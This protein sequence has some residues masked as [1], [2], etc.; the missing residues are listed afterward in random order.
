MKDASMIIG[1][2][3]TA[4]KARDFTGILSIQVQTIIFSYLDLS[5]LLRCT[6][7]SRRWQRIILDNNACFSSLSIKSANAIYRTK[8]PQKV[9][10][11]ICKAAKG[12]VRNMVI[13]TSVVPTSQ[14]ALIK[15]SC[16][17]KLNSLR[18]FTSG[19]PLRLDASEYYLP[20]SR[21]QYAKL[22][23]L[24]LS[25]S[26]C[27]DDLVKLLHNIPSL[28]Q[29]K[30]SD[31]IGFPYN[32]STFKNVLK[33]YHSE[34]SNVRYLDATVSIAA[35]MPEL[36]C[37]EP[38]LASL[39]PNLEEIVLNDYMLKC[40]GCLVNF[41]NVKRLTLRQCDTDVGI[42]ELP[43]S[44]K[45]FKVIACQKIGKEDT[46]KLSK[47]EIDT[48][49]LIDCYSIKSRDIDDFLDY[50]HISLTHLH[51]INSILPDA[52]TILYVSMEFPNLQYVKL[53]QLPYITD[54]D[55]I[56]LADNLP[57]LSTL[58]IRDCAEITAPGIMKMVKKASFLTTLKLDSS[59]RVALEKPLKKL[60]ISI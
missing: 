17:V 30:I 34:K 55:L 47:C 46:L 53:A 57:L 56:T 1:G 5:T 18:V 33:H 12:G 20:E 42:P 35:D 27:L 54:A 45:Y 25:C 16:Y 14:L 15:E 40:T 3:K 60:G 50:S 4:A 24:T 23:Q 21:G 36:L 52:D 19:K 9:V 58:I 38:T 37:G 13:D 22:H 11:K 28:R 7:V 39:M 26:V 32:P 41:S 8:I 31:L 2:R 48:F 51:L 49:C 6:A 59:L 43:E 10:E 44:L 29:L